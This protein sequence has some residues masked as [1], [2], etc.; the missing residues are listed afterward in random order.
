MHLRDSNYDFPNTRKRKYIRNDYDLKLL[1]QKGLYP[2]EYMDS[3]ERFNDTEFPSHDKS[4]SSLSDSKISETEYQ[5][6]L[7]VWNH[8][9][10]KH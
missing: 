6:G 8:F 7:S 2:Y 9:K 3:W 1:I 4:Y 5:R 10:I